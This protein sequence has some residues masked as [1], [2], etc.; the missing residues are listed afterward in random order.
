MR[1]CLAATLVLVST[2]CSR[3]FPRQVAQ[4][5][6]D[7]CSATYRMTEKQKAHSRI[8]KEYKQGPDKNLCRLVE[9]SPAP[10]LV[11][12]AGLRELPALSPTPHGYP[13]WLLRIFAHEADAVVVG[14]VKSKSSALTEDGSFIFTDAQV[15]VQ[16]VIKDNLAAPIP[17]NTEITV[18]RPGGTIML[19][20]KEVR[21]ADVEFDP[22]QVN[23][24]YVLFLTFIPE[25]G[26]YRAFSERSFQLL[27][28]I[29]VKVTRKTAFVLPQSHYDPEA[30]VNEVRAAVVS[31]ATW[32]DGQ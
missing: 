15:E 10:L 20:G 21:A 24:R 2:R 6:D 25:T 17:R 18:T 26:G 5:E 32:R 23:G 12:V 19:K 30:F 7:P 8:Y 4:P 1:F 13:N 28:G 11:Q 29:V 27:P 16:E 9:G 31:A 3:A 22:F 14:V